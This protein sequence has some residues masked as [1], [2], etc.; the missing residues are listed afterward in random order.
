MVAECGGRW[1]DMVVR[2]RDKGAKNTEVHSRASDL[3]QA[4]VA[5]TNPDPG[6]SRSV[7]GSVPLTMMQSQE[8][9]ILALRQLATNSSPNDDPASIHIRSGALFARLKALNPDPNPPTR[10]HKQ[11]TP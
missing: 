5:P 11:I 4:L 2:V 10:T 1:S 3:D 7:P 6:P 8:E 9:V